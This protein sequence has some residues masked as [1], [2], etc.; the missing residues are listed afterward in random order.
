M[1]NSIPTISVLLSTYNRDHL[2]EGFINDLFKQ[3]FQD[4]ELVILNNGSTDQTS[5]ILKNFSNNHRIRIFDHKENL[6]CVGGYNFLL[7]NIKGEWFAMLGDDD[8]IEHHSFETMLKVLKDVDPQIDAITANAI[9]LNT[10]ELSGFGLD[11]DQYL[12]IEK[13]I[14]QTSGEFFGIT[15]TK[16]LGNHR[17]NEKLNGEE[18]TFYFKLDAIAKRYYIHQPLKF[19]GNP[20]VKNITT[21]LREFNAPVRTELYKELLT[22]PFYW[23]QLKKYVPNRYI[24]RCLRGWFFLK[25]ANEKKDADQYKN[26]L[27]GISIPFKYQIVKLMIGI[28]NPG[29]LTGFYGFLKNSKFAGFIS[30]FFVKKYSQI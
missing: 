19:F 18:D 1:K 13:L 11:K 16:L 8:R 9:D 28:A 29:L 4:F 2:L 15:K 25:L 10:G 30:Q 20:E 12:P 5:Q 3:T 6:G 7:D 26:M 22:E 17:F 27:K 23:E 14:T 24:A 21:E